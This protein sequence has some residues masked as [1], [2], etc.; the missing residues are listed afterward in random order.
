[1]HQKKL[2]CAIC[3]F[4]MATWIFEL[5]RIDE[6]PTTKLLPSSLA[7]VLSFLPDVQMDIKQRNLRAM[8]PHVS[9]L[10]RTGELLNTSTV[11]GNLKT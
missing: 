4:L 11:I 1:M 7:F 2:L 9:P 8:C 3:F 5:W 6:Q 10:G